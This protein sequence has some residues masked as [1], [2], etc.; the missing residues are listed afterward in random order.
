VRRNLE[1]WGTEAQRQLDARETFVSRYKSRL[2]SLPWKTEAPTS[3]AALAELV[4]DAQG[5]D[6]ALLGLSPP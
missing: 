2:A 5:L 1:R 3:V 4:S 6:L